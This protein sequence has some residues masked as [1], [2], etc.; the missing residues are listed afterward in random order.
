NAEFLATNQ[1]TT[2]DRSDLLEEIRLAVLGTTDMIDSLIIFSRTGEP[3]QRRLQDIEPIV[4]RAAEV[5]E[6]HPEFAGVRLEIQTAPDVGSAFCDSTQIERALC[7]LMLNA[8]QAAR[9]VAEEPRVKVRLSSEG[10]L[11]VVRIEDNGTGVP[12]CV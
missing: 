12:E 11:I 5:V 9:Q 4:R 8:S 10:D 3:A 6:A 2:Q 7:N 1:L